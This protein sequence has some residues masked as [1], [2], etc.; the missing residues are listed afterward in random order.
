MVTLPFIVF[1]VA[2]DSRSI[3]MALLGVATLS[4]SIF[5]ACYTRNQEDRR[6]RVNIQLICIILQLLINLFCDIF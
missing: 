5:V 6:V 3:E 2:I 4:V 1:R